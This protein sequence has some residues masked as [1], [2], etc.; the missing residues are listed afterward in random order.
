[1][2]RRHGMTLVEVLPVG[3]VGTA[4]GVPIGLGLTKFSVS[5]I[6]EYIPEMAVSSWGLR[7]A[8][9]GGLAISILSGFIP[10]LQTMNVSPLSATRPLS[11][12]PRFKAALI[13][14]VCGVLL[15]IVL[16]ATGL[17]RVPL[18]PIKTWQWLLLAIGL[19]QS[20]IWV[21]VLVVGWLLALGARSRITLESEPGIFNAMQV[22][23]ALLSLAA[24]GLAIF[25]VTV[26]FLRRRLE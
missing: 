14:G 10:A 11:G 6:P 25:V 2:R 12:R 17:G 1:M 3:L 16:I 24:L 9:I 7:I 5:M 20:P 19:S 26:S 23:L 18:T 4:A 13:A 8:V 21:G 15:I 22:G